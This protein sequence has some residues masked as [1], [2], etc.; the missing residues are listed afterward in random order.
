MFKGVHRATVSASPVASRLLGLSGGFS[1]SRLLGFSG[2]SGGFSASRLA[3]RLRWLLGFS[4]CPV[5]SRLLG[6][7]GGFS[8]SR[9][10]GISACVVLRGL[11][12]FSASVVT[13]LI[14]GPFC[15]CF[16]NW[17]AEWP[18]R[19]AFDKFMRIRQFRSVFHVLLEQELLKSNSKAESEVSK[20]HVI[21]SEG[22]QNDRG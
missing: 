6:F 20:S 22:G 16:G 8:A 21:T 3:R 9:L 2:L 17:A 1:A 10:L 5:A 7:S 13:F 19:E 12:G 14:L 18:F 15:P 4:A 11:L